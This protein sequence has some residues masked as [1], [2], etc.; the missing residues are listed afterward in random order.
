MVYSVNDLSVQAV[1]H[2][3][4]ETASSYHVKGKIL[5]IVGP[6][7]KSSLDWMNNDKDFQE[8]NKKIYM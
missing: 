1:W 6:T 4:H 2:Q 3:P 8:K 5:L 7:V